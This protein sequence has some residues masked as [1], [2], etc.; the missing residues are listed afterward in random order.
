MNFWYSTVT[1]FLILIFIAG[2]YMTRDAKLFVKIALGLLII[3]AVAMYFA[4]HYNAY[5]ER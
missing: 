3:W 1:L 5:H 2:L 4:T